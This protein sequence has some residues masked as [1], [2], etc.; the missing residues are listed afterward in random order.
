MPYLHTLTTLLPALQ[1]PLLL[2][3]AVEPKPLPLLGRADPAGNNF[4]EAPVDASRPLD[5]FNLFAAAPDA[6]PDV[7]C[8]ALC[9]RWCT[10]GWFVVLLLLL[11]IL[12]C[13]LLGGTGAALLLLLLPL[14]VALPEAL[15]SPAMRCGN[16]GLD[17]RLLP[18]GAFFAA[19]GPADHL[20]GSPVELLLLLL[21]LLVP[22][23]IAL[24]SLL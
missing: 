11:P 16:V 12:P 19:G 24:S 5:S 1:V 14:L 17:L 18:A 2:L 15:L 10:G 6:A 8:R 7:C 13:A 4:W 21:L 22:L 20:E 23:F 9:V 3:L